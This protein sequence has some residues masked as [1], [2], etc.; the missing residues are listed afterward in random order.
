MGSKSWL[1]EKCNKTNQPLESM[2]NN[3]RTRQKQ[4]TRNEKNLITDATDIKKT[5]GGIMNNFF[6]FLLFR[7]VL[8]AYGGSQASG[9]IRAVA[10]GLHQS[11]SSTG[12]EPHLQ[13]TPQ[14]MAT[15]DP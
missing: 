13:A 5:M 4:P 9:L 6:F 2:T 10:A 3:K 14:L 15:P 7:A 11:H 1:F 8:M 12:P